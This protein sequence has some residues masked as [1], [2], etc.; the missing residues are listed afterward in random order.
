VD[1]GGTATASEEGQVLDELIDLYATQHG[2]LPT[3]DAVRQWMETLQAVRV[4]RVWA[5]LIC[6]QSVP[7]GLWP[8]CFVAAQASE[9]AIQGNSRRKGAL[10]DLS[11]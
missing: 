10:P 1:S 3:D 6:V 2:E 5:L 11:A 9:E 8:A 7:I 4:I